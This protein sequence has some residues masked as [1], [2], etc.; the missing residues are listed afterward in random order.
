MAL[1]PAERLIASSRGLSRRSQAAESAGR[2]R[3]FSNQ[4]RT[5]RPRLVRN[6]RPATLSAHT[7][8]RPSDVWFEMLARRHFRTDHVMAD[9]DLFEMLAGAALRRSAGSAYSP[10]LRVL[11][12]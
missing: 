7:P 4:P 11:S 2:R 3:S 10:V 12:D 5:L 6:A 1:S 8:H 9:I